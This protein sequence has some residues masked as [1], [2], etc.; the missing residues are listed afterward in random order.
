MTRD[1]AAARGRALACPRYCAPSLLPVQTEEEKKKEVE[2]AEQQRKIMEMMQVRGASRGCLPAA[3]WPCLRLLSAPCV[4][5]F[6][7]LQK[8]QEEAAAKQ[9][10]AAEGASEGD[11]KAEGAERAAAEVEAGSEA[12]EAK[13]EAAPAAAAEGEE[14]LAAAAAAEAEAEAA[15]VKTLAKAEAAAARSGGEQ[16]AGQAMRSQKDITLAKDLELRDRWAAWRRVRLGARRVLCCALPHAS[17]PF[18][19]PPGRPAGRTSTAT[20]CCTA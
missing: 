16:V 20:F 11:A 14:Q 18:H 19:A 1:R 8:A 15:K 17:H 2:E 10:A 6:M 7:A 13:P 5:L 9:K 4:C 12:A 3:T